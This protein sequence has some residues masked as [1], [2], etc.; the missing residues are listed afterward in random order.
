MKL[1]MPMV[2]LLTTGFFWTSS[3]QSAAE[4]TKT[5][6]RTAIVYANGM[7]NLPSHAIGSM[8]LLRKTMI[9][10]GTMEKITK[11][12][13]KVRFLHVYN[14]SESLFSQLSEVLGQKVDD[15]VTL[16]RLAFF[17]NDLNGSQEPVKKIKVGD[18][19][20]DL[21]P[22][23][24]DESKVDDEDLT[25]HV[26]QYRDLMRSG[27]RV[28][29]VSHSQGNF[30]SNQSY[31]LLNQTEQ[32]SYRQVQV[33]TP[34]SHIADGS[35]RFTTFANDLVMAIVPLSLGPKTI[36]GRV[37]P[38]P[39]AHSFDSA[40]LTTAA[41]K[42]QIMN[43][44]I[45]AANAAKYP[46]GAALSPFS[47]TLTWDNN[48][49]DLDLHITEPDNTHVYQRA[50]TGIA[51]KL[52]LDSVS[53]ASQELYLGYCGKTVPGTYKLSVGN[54]KG[55]QIE[56]GTLR[57]TAGN[58]IHTKDFS[59]ETSEDHPQGPRSI[60]KPHHLAT[61]VVSVGSDGEPVYK[62]SAE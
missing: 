4:C 32:A 37:F 35:A 1:T 53:G 20:V 13:A 57:I 38:D 26:R 5:S 11:D 46:A 25:A 14:E 36:L 58:E 50:K 55:E 30:Y 54:F 40:Y 9:S 23:Y 7:F 61:V 43:H 21:E 34:A 31:R 29:T 48:A 28:V 18:K 41:A 45:Q 3:A 10:T 17:Q 60:L 39:L 27:H 12:P 52:A 44:I 51:G 49:A 15:V 59:I 47:V 6:D 42:T 16:V 56:T 8:S 2:I 62:F 22:Y 33:A 19:E 24:A